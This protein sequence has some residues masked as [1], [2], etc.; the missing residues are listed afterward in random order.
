MVRVSNRGDGGFYKLG[1]EEY[2]FFYYEL[3]I[4]GATHTEREDLLL[5]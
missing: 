3:A 1:S 2:C 5:L 4:P